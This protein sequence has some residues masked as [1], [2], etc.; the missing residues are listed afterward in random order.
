VE[1]VKEEEEEMLVL[2]E[3]VIV[4]VEEERDMIAEGVEVEVPLQVPIDNSHNSAGR[5][6]LR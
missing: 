5:K 1:E 4:I 6:R 3:S 2:G